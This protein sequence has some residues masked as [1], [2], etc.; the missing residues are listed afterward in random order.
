MILQRQGIV[1]SEGEEE[2]QLWQELGPAITP[3][4]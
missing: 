2:G 4:S 1:Q 3:M